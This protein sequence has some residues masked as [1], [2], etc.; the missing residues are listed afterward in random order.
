[1]E[2]DEVETLLPR[3]PAHGLHALR[4]RALFLVLYNTGARVVEIADLLIEHLDLGPQPR[5][6]LLV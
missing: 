4:Y 1:L 3:L 5:V 2:R 6:S